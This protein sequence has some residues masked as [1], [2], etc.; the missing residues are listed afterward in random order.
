MSAVLQ[1]NNVQKYI[2]N[3]I[4]RK[5]QVRYTCSFYFILYLWPMEEV[6]DGLC[7]DKVLSSSV[8]QA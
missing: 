5:K 3:T 7:K 4:Y 6:S 1:R 8:E 2:E